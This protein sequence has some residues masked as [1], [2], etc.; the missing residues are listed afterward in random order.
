MVLQN[1]FIF[2]GTVLDNI[3]LG[4]EF[5]L[6]DVENVCKTLGIYDYIERLPKG[7]N[8][9]LSTEGKNISLGERQLISFA[10]AL[11]HNPRILILDEATSSIDSHTEELIEKGTRI[12][13][14]GR[15]SIIIAH[16]LSTIKHVNRIYVLNKGR[17]VEE[18]T[19]EE[20]LQRKGLYYE[21]YKS[22]YK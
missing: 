6:E 9:E 18:G 4:D 7:L 8:T 3:T 2:K 17:I 11:I 12:L 21:F 5:P 15:T 19:H 10:R 22:Q 20:L 13:M 14:E 1:V 16:R